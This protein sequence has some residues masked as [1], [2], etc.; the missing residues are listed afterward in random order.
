MVNNRYVLRLN[1]IAVACVVRIKLHHH[2]VNSFLVSLLVFVYG[3]VLVYSCT[4][5]ANL[6]L[7]VDSHHRA[8]KVESCNS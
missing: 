6:R 2:V 7:V 8:R 5:L 1:F 4:T 3:D